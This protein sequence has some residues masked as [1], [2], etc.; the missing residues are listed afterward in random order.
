MGRKD[1]K[2]QID[3]AVAT[4]QARYVQRLRA[5]LERG[6]TAAL[7]DER[8]QFLA[9]LRSHGRRPTGVVSLVDADVLWLE[10]FIRRLDVQP[11]ARGATRAPLG[12]PLQ[13]RLQSAGAELRAALQDPRRQRFA[14]ALLERL[15]GWPAPDP[16]D[17]A[18]VAAAARAWRRSPELMRVDREFAEAL[19]PQTARRLHGLSRLLYWVAVSLLAFAALAALGV[20]RAHRV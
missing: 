20:A 13:R 19:C 4:A 8:W 17:S 11:L 5:L 2:R 12:E 7:A 14:H 3:R 1:S 9:V 10:E 15:Q 6:D 18:L 16:P